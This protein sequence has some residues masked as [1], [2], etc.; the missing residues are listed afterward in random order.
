MII[1]DPALG[2]YITNYA[3]VV[4]YLSL[5]GLSMGDIDEAALFAPYDKAWQKDSGQSAR[6]KLPSR[7]GFIVTGRIDAE[8]RYRS[9]K[10]KGWKE[11]RY[12][13]KKVLWWTTGANYIRDPKSGECLA[14]VGENGVLV[15]GSD[16]VMK[17]V[18]DVQG[19]KNQG[20][21]ADSL[22]VTTM[23]SFLADPEIGASLFVIVTNEIRSVFKSHFMSEQSGS[24]KQGVDVIAA[25]AEYSGH[26]EE[27]GLSI[28]KSN[29]DYL[30]K[31]SFQLD[32]ADRAMMLAG[33][34]QLASGMSGLLPGNEL[35]RVMLSSLR[36]SR[37]GKIVG[38]E[39]RLTQ[40][41]LLDILSKPRK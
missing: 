8:A 14:I 4:A 34:I 29:G 22:F 3:P 1:D 10:A 18:L 33:I 11:E 17:G 27:F 12:V 28:K 36:V 31:G 25:L 15:G 26:L 2:R 13:N 5:L 7:A 40:N 39:S 35:D 37:L 21:T 19:G 24:G 9:I 32:S 41:Q 23:R 16:E 30:L 6:S 38:L 20:L